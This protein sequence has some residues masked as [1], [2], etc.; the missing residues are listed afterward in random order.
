M[1]VT[2]E[3]V[4]ELLSAADFGDRMRG[5][6]QLPQLESATAFE[7]LQLVVKDRHPRIRYAAI[8]KM[9]SFGG[10]NLDASLELLR[11]RL[12]NDPEPDVQAVAADALAALKLTSAFPDLAQVYHQSPEWLVQFSIIAALGEMGDPR[13]FD[14]LSE[15]IS[16]DN[17]LIK[18]AALA[19]LGELGDPRG[20]ALL[21]P[22][23]SDPD[24]QIR[25]RVAQSLSR[26]GGEEGR[27]TLNTL[28]QDSV[29][30]VA[31]AAQELL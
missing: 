5:I 2:P 11:D 31:Q 30:Q 14:L 9:D 4:K 20:V 24:W 26:L 28:A 12:L 16:S 17:E 8:S 25:F 15:A 23:A 1:S 22:L 21:I 27:A 19:S 3:S 10:E 7:L 18:T 6:N 13:G 29:E